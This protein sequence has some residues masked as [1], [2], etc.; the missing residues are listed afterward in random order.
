MKSIII[1]GNGY[2]K[3]SKTAD[4]NFSLWVSGYAFIGNDYYPANLL[5]QY[6]LRLLEGCI[7]R[8]RVSIIKKMIPKFNGAWALI[9]A[10][11]KS[12]LSAVDRFRSIPI[13]YSTK[14]EYILLSDNSHAILKLLGNTEID[15][16]CASE[17]LV[18]GY[19]SGNETIYKNL[20]Q[21]Q[22]GE[23]VEAKN[24]LGDTIKLECYRYYRYSYKEFL[25]TGEE[26]LEDRL[27]KIIH[28][29]FERFANSLRNKTIVIPLSGGLDSRLIA[30]MFK[31]FGIENLFCFSYGKI[32]NKESE[33]SKAVANILGYKWLFCEYNYSLWYKWFREEKIQE[34]IKR[35]G[36]GAS[37]FHIQDLPAIR[38]ILKEIG[39]NNIVVIP[40]HSGDFITGS[41]VKKGIFNVNEAL[42]EL[43]LEY[44]LSRSYNLWNWEKSYPQIKDLFIERI[45]K[46]LLKHTIKNEIDANEVF[47]NWVFENKVAKY[48]INSVRV[49]EFFNCEWMLPWWDYEFMDFLLSINIDMRYS[50]KLFRNILVKKIYIDDLAE[51]TKIPNFGGTPLLESNPV[52]NNKSKKNN[53]LQNFVYQG[54]RKILPDFIKGLY[55]SCSIYKYNFNH[56]DYMS[57]YGTYMRSDISENKAYL[58]LLFSKQGKSLNISLSNLTPSVRHIIKPYMNRSIL[59]SGIVGLNTA[60]YLARIID[61][62]NSR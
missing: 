1:L 42:Y 58:K 59:N 30:A 26:E 29:V 57:W 46:S 21:I 50:R 36:N 24:T 13:F 53:R 20:H 43:V 48:V 25:N 18:T 6:I 62:Y 3:W 23:I 7:E 28:N 16:I 17:L 51:L 45:Q 61:E 40:G 54:L 19:V 34:F 44:I 9:Y 14:G 35:C 47:E 5:L 2:P 8:D 27:N 11:N 55:R 32:G 49:Y 38:E 39:F 52:A 4:S 37:V 22:P 33:V 15:D 60:Y 41:F 31:R 56:Y 12:V 10:D